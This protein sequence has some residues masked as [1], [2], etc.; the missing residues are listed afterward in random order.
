MPLRFRRLAALCAFPLLL[1]ACAM[2]EGAADGGAPG[3]YPGDVPGARMTLAR[4]DDRVKTVQLHPTANEAGLPVISLR[5]TETLTLSFDLLDEGT[6]RPLSV[7]FYHA[8]RSWR[9]DL[10]PSEYLSTF[11]SDD[12]RDYRPSAATEV[13]YVHYE[14]EFPNANIGFLMSGNFIVR[15]AEQGQEGAVLLER[16]FFVSEEAAEVE[17]GFQTG[18][19]GGAAV[20]QPLVRLRPG[21][22]LADAQPFDYAVCFARNGQFERTRCAQEPSLLGLALYQFYLDHTEAFPAERPFYEVDLGLLQVGPQI[23]NVDYSAT[24]DA[25]LL[26]PD[27]ARFGGDVRREALTGQPLVEAVYRSGGYPDTQGQYVTVHF[28]YVP[29]GERQAGGPVLLTGAFNGWQLDP[30]L[31]LTWDPATGRYE[32]SLLL[33]QGLYL[34][35]YVVDD[36]TAEPEALLLQPSLYTA[37]VYVRDLTRITDRLV[38]VRS[39]VSQ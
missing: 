10:V 35:Q 33:K 2:T 25:V 1:T 15:V 38:A 19:S 4:T 34:Y 39:A 9:R 29:A 16:A 37:L 6:G 13:P 26:D 12:I 11:L 20:V 5:S 8:D 30:A 18:F 24:P 7:Y 23:A 14:Y 28:R 22:Q 3:A 36:P 21:P 31:A 32:G 17:M 27:H